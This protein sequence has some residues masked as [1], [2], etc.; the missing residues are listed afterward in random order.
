MESFAR[1]R[2]AQR[3]IS[4]RWLLWLLLA[5]AAGGAIFYAALGPTGPTT[6]PS[7][8]APADGVVLRGQPP[9]APLTLEWS[10]GFAAL[11]N[12]R[13]RPASHF[14]ICV[15]DAAAGQQCAWPGTFGDSR[16]PAYVW[17]EEAWRLR[18]SATA[19]GDPLGTA[20]LPVLVDAPRH[21]TYDVPQ[22]LPS[23]A[24]GRPLTWTVGACSEPS[25]NLCRYAQP[26]RTLTLSAVNLRPSDVSDAAFSGIIRVDVLATNDGDVPS[27][28]F[29]TTVSVWELLLDDSGD[30][31]TDVNAADIGPDFEIVDQ[32]GARRPISQLPPAAG[33]GYDATGVRGILKPGGIDVTEVDSYAGLSA[34]TELGV[35]QVDVSVTAGR[36]PTR[37]A[38]SVGVDPANE[39]VEFDETDNSS[40]WV[41]DL[42]NP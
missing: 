34:G 9:A 31:R 27:G 20:H 32:S 16:E 1:T 42:F 22:G 26:V 19:I 30:P 17:T 36:G 33:G 2:L 15:F 4:V 13:P 10:H 41:G 18:R 29:E 23:S 24:L 14:V 40:V 28:P 37:F 8:T 6:A 21:Y 7:L 5:A 12:Q 35:A 25:N 3:G 38:V 11:D 39:V